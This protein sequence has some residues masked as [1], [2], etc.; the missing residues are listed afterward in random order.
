MVLLKITIFALPI[1]EYK[2]NT[3]NAEFETILGIK[4]IKK[5]KKIR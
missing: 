1:I 5:I 3:K 2:I 4:P